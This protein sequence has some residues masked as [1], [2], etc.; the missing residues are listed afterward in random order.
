VNPKLP[1]V[2]LGDVSGVFSGNSAPQGK[3]DFDPEGRVFIR[4]SDVGAIHIGEISDSRDRLAEGVGAKFREFPPGTVLFPKSGA[5]TFSNHRVITTI[6]AF[7]S[8][9]LAGVVADEQK[10][11]PRFLFYSLQTVDAKTLIQDQGYPSLTISAI[12]AIPIQLPPLEEQR[13]IVK[14]LDEATNSINALK[15]NRHAKIA[16]LDGYADLVAGEMLSASSEPMGEGGEVGVTVDR[17][18][19]SLGEVAD[20][21]WGNTSLTKKA[22]VEDGEFLAISATGPD[23]RIGHAEH[24][25]YTPVISAIGANCGR[26]FLPEEEFTA[27]KNT[28]T[29][30]PNRDTL[31]GPYLYHLLKAT[32]FPIR[33]AAQPFLSKGDIQAIVI[34][35]PRSIEEQRRI[36]KVLDEANEAKQHAI[37][38]C[39]QSLM[40]IG[41]LQDSLM[42]KML[43]GA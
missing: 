25:A 12:A 43:A 6:P 17:T 32:Q 18:T 22:Y 41:V 13:R 31:D 4:T 5:S 10:V 26:M 7:V 2:A 19:A 39:E 3:H 8:S 11:L 42:T 40:E 16:A 1:T 38:V 30:T 36:V 20:V 9:H 28:M 23:G 37:N 24:S 14:V 33:G 15:Q 27:I 29:V 34:E 35:F 21:D